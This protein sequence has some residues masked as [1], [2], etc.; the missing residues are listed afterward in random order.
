MYHQSGH[1]FVHPQ[2]TPPLHQ[3][4]QHQQQPPPPPYPWPPYPPAPAGAPAQQPPS[5][6]YQAYPYYPRPSSSHFDSGHPPTSYPLAGVPTTPLSPSIATPV[7][8]PPANS[9]DNNALYKAEMSETQIQNW[10]HSRQQQNIKVEVPSLAVQP[11]PPSSSSSS[12]YNK[13]HSSQLQRQD[14][15]PALQ[16]RQSG[17]FGG[18]LP[19]PQP[20]WNQSLGTNGMS[21]I[22]ATGPYPGF[23]A[24]PPNTN[25]LFGPT[26][27]EHQ[28]SLTESAGSIQSSVQ[29]SSLTTLDPALSAST[30]I[31]ARI[32][33]PY[34]SS[35]YQPEPQVRHGPSAIEEQSSLTEIGAAAGSTQVN[36][37]ITTS[38]QVGSSCPTSFQNLGHRHNSQSLNAS[39]IEEQS[40]LTEVD[41]M[42]FPIEAQS[43]LTELGNAPYTLEE[44]SALTELDDMPHPLESQSALTTLDDLA[45]GLKEQSALTEI[46][47]L[48][49]GLSDQSSLTT[50]DEPKASPSNSVKAKDSIT[51]PPTRVLSAT[52]ATLVTSTTN[53]ATEETISVSSAISPDMQAFADTTASTFSMSNWTLPTDFMN[54]SVPQADTAREVSEM[55]TESGSETGS[56]RRRS[57]TTMQTGTDLEETRPRP[58]PPPKPASLTAARQ[59]NPQIGLSGTQLTISEEVYLGQIPTPPTDDRVVLVPLQDGSLHDNDREDIGDGE[60]EDEE[61][62]ELDI[63]PLDNVSDFI[64][65]L[66]S[67]LSKSL[68]RSGSG[69][70][71][72]QESTRFNEVK[73]TDSSSSR[74]SGSGRVYETPLDQSRVEEVVIEQQ[75]DLQNGELQ[76]LET[77][78]FEWTFTES[79]QTTYERIFSLW[80]RPAE[81]CVTSDIAGKVFMT[82][83]L[84]N[85][86]LP[87]IWQLLNPEEKPVLSRT[88]F[89]A[90][91]HLVNC[92]AVGYELPE[93]LPDELMISAASV[94]R[95]TIPSCPVQGPLFI[96]NHVESITTMN[97]PSGQPIPSTV[98]QA[99][100]LTPTPSAGSDFMDAYN[101]PDSTYEAVA[102][103]NNLA[104]R[105]GDMDFYARNSQQEQQYQLQ[106]QYSLPG[107]AL[108]QF[109]QQYSLPDSAPNQFLQQYSLSDPAPSQF[110]QQYQ[111]SML[112]LVDDRSIVSP[113][114]PSPRPANSSSKPPPP[115]KVIIPPK[116]GPHALHD[117]P[118]GAPVFVN[119]ED[120]L[121]LQMRDI[122][123]SNQSPPGYVTSDSAPASSDLASNTSS[124]AVVTSSVINSR[125]HIDNPE[126]YASAPDAWD[127]DGAP[128][129]LDVEGN[130]IRYRTDFKNDMVV[131]ASVT[132]NHPINPKS[133]VFYF[134]ITIDQFKEVKGSAISVGIASKSLRKNCQVGW[135]LDSWG[136]HSDD[137]FLYFGNGKQNIKYAYE[138]K[139]NDVVGC[140]V[141][142]LDRAVFFTL[143]GDMLGVAF[144]FIK[145]TI[146]LYPAIGLSHAGTEINANFGDQTFLFNILDYKK[147]VMSK[148]IQS[149]LLIT[150]NNGSRNEKVFQVLPDC[151]SVIANGKD[152]GCIRGP[153]VSPRDKDVFYFEITI[154]YM[155][156]TEN[157][158]IMVG[159][160]GKD[161]DMKD[162]LGWRGNS[163]GYSSESGDFFS[164]SSNRSSLNAPS[165]SGKMRARARG[166]PFRA[167]SVVG[168]GVDFASRELFFT[169]NGECLGQAFYEVDVLDCFPCVSV[170]DGG[171]G[172]GGPLTQL[173]EQ[174][175]PK[176][177]ST[178]RLTKA[179]SSETSDDRIG[180][181]FKAN[182]GQYPFMFDLPGFEASGGQ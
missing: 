60:D 168:C 77:T 58:T 55:A 50:L 7:S 160:C 24:S 96:P 54:P 101:I 56:F 93:D 97:P 27:V 115:E 132:A 95:I 175:G 122:Q 171:G 76:Q 167:G 180:F 134:E 3:Q 133:K 86:D 120:S 117:L 108:S 18:A 22:S 59:N 114:S 43:S 88:Q 107:P 150:W 149:P 143:N 29:E 2:P 124:A 104:Q 170:V 144:R 26:P 181:E 99:Q 136:Y 35:Q 45:Y 34:S 166:P 155:P 127:Y 8:I 162:C 147:R 38:G 119:E 123:N 85:Q 121:I 158:T 103:A 105:P 142:F 23:V 52:D 39:S 111:P 156:A 128:P 91:L 129:E 1:P 9:F 67:D 64:R 31:N 70:S 44:Q 165:Q 48:P 51:A 21:P 32:S 178:A 151:L 153:K 62:D 81:E 13:Q 139:E 154:L 106:Q 125:H 78:Q 83:G 69:S 11:T 137:G 82:L 141:N 57:P 176:D 94:G 65:A 87:K 90:G 131:S 169:L 16:S 152:A 72:L 164:R 5:P 4:Q 140:G 36:F 112:G 33:R 6:L 73:R 75:D 25:F 163:Y 100:N 130:N 17:A 37:G 19:S 89:I 40:S 84:G 102:V 14:Q 145:D 126:L 61:D 80:E 79:E 173:R 15:L 10:Q 179:S 109:Q 71:S 41:N 182:F 63:S 177:S 74:V 49:N 118:E 20:S 28:S 172:V 146:P 116:P 42:P 159:I 66:Q 92:K 161:Q 98:T 157:G 12:S 30:G 148:P 135:D 113:P 47:N 46:D 68:S 138:Y 174:P 53:I 110:S